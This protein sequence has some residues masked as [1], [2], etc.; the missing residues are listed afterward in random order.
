SVGR[1]ITYRP[2]KQG[3]QSGATVRI[4]TGVAEGGEISIYYD[5]LIAK[6]VT[7]AASRGAAIEAQAAALDQFAIDGIQHNIPF[8]AALMQNNRWREG[9]LST[10]FIRDEFGDVLRPQTP[11]GEDL[12]IL[13][14][15]ATAIDH[16]NNVRRRQITHQMGGSKVRFNSQR[17]VAIG[18]LRC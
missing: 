11:A 6:L 17:I 3:M 18:D 14:A 12:T 9:R 4:D 5:P 1:L 15:V 2:P 13:T 7:H 16:L 8:L 10:G